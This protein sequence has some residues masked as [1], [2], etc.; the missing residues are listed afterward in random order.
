M[1]TAAHSLE[2]ESCF[3][4]YKKKRVG[5]CHS[6]TR[7]FLGR[8]IAPGFEGMRRH[9]HASPVSNDESRII[10]CLRIPKFEIFFAFPPH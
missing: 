8:E 9:R 1:S 4:A 6:P 3:P 7:F 10:L 5:E 2:A